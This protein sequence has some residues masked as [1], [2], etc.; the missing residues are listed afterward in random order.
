MVKSKPNLRMEAQRIDVKEVKSP[1]TQYLGTKTDSVSPSLVANQQKSMAMLEAY[2][3]RKQKSMEKEEVRPESE[4]TLEQYVSQSK[5]S[6][7]V[8]NESD[9]D[10]EIEKFVSQARPLEDFGIPISPHMAKISSGV[11]SKQNTPTKYDE[12]MELEEFQS[13]PQQFFTG[14][15]ESDVDEYPTAT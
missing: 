14:S 4:G 5:E 8:P 15:K 13:I 1:L 3:Q 2:I 9:A 7:Q 10:D 6:A 12:S 11:P